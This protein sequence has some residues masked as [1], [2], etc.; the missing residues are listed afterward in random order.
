MEVVNDSGT[1]RGLNGVSSALSRSSILSG[2]AQQIGF[3]QTGCDQEAA[4]ASSYD[5][6]DTPAVQIN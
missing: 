4:G 1:K 3:S 2:E 5:F 6:G